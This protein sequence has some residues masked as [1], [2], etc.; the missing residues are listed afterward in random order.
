[1]V[2][3]EFLHALP[4]VDRHEDAAHQGN[5]SLVRADVRCRLLAA[6]ML[7]AR[8]QR[9][10]ESA[11]AVTVASLTDEPTRHLANILV[12]GGDYAAV[13]TAES[14]RYAE[15]L[16]FHAHN[17]G[18]GRRLHDAQRNRLSDRH[19]QQRTLLVSDLADRRDVFDGAKEVWRLDK[20]ASGLIV[21]RH[22]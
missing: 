3:R 15:R 9:Q 2:R 21:D 4:T 16:R 20:D 22:L 7:L 6:D 18:G 13:G 19:D 17:V 11:L 1:V 8:R 5:K 14:Q 10:D 12:A